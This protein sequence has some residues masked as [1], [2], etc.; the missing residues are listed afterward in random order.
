[1]SIRKKLIFSFTSLALLVGAV[2]GIGIAAL[3]R[4]ESEARHNPADVVARHASRATDVLIYVTPVGV[5][6][7]VA[8]GVVLSS[9]F[10]SRLK[11][12]HDLGRRPEPIT[13][14]TGDE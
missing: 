8:L 13:C 3:I 6:L 1:M 10:G 12:F 14:D 9:A 2:G 7:A 11:A 5:A 4:L